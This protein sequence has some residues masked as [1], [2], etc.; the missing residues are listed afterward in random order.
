MT[1][2]WRTNAHAFQRLAAEHI[3]RWCA[4][5]AKAR[6]KW[7]I[8]GELAALGLDLPMRDFER[9][10]QEAVLEGVPIGSS[11]KGFFWCEMAEDF[12]VARAYLACRFGPMKARIEALERASRRIP[13]QGSPR[14]NSKSKRKRR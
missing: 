9:L 14:L 11:R 12:A 13:R 4:G 7:R 3:R 5:A 2:A 1:T 6:P 8:R 10:V